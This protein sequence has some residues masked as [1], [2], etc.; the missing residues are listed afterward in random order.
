MKGLTLEDLEFDPPIGTFPSRNP[1]PSTLQGWVDLPRNPKNPYEE[2]EK[3]KHELTSMTLSYYAGGEHPKCIVELSESIRKTARQV[4]NSKDK[5]AKD[6]RRK[7]LPRHLNVTMQKDNLNKT[8][9]SNNVII[10]D[11]FK[12]KTSDL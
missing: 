9:M 8:I 1:R 7:W 5:P 2:R 11:K 4:K 3:T 6:P 10:Q 12:R